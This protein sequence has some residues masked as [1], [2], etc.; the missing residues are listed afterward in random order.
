[1]TATS[2]AT[3]AYT[4]LL[5]V[6][7]TVT[8]G[9]HPVTVVCTGPNGT[10]NANAL[11]MVSPTATTGYSPWTAIVVAIVLLVLGSLCLVVM[12]RRR[13]QLRTS[14]SQ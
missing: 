10:I 13:L 9:S 5:V 4:A 6:P 1:M 11:I 14:R 12:H 8:P 7:R 3:G 2:S